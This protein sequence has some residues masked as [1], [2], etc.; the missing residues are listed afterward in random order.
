M[1]PGQC[2]CT[3]LQDFF[4]SGKCDI[5]ALKVLETTFKY[6]FVQCFIIYEH[7]IYL[8]SIAKFRTSSCLWRA[9]TMDYKVKS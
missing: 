6:K 5:V 8:S 3:W 9:E 7:F 2:D 4:Q 1:L